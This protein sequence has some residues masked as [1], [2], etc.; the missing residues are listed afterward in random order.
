MNDWY[1][2]FDGR[3]VE[4]IPAREIIC[5]VYYYVPLS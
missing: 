2:K 5:S 1:A 3:I 4:E